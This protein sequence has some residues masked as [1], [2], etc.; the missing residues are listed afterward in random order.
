MAKS[1]LFATDASKANVG[2][3]KFDSNI[4]ILSHV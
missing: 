1:P 2:T 4:G 3:V